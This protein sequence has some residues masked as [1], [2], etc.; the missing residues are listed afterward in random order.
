MKNRCTYRLVLALILASSQMVFS[1]GVNDLPPL[2]RNAVLKQAG[3]SKIDSIVKEDDQG[4]VFYSVVK[5]AQKGKT[6]DFSIDQEG[7]LVL[8]EISLDA[9]PPPVRKTMDQQASSAKVLKVEKS[10]DLGSVEYHITTLDKAGNEGGFAIEA[11]GTLASVLVELGETPPAVQKTISAQLAGRKIESIEK[12][13]DGDGF[14]FD[15]EVIAANGRWEKFTVSAA[16]K[17]ESITTTFEELTMPVQKTIRQHLGTGKIREILKMMPG[18]PKGNPTEVYGI[19]EGK[20]FNIKI[21]P[22]GKFLGMLE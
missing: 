8:E 7:Q 2:V 17:L 16:G 9:V 13:I 22:A 20:P 21:G 4:Q 6:M 5:I 1:L 14:E 11:D 12:M 19:K 15:V 10:Y 18:G 3:D